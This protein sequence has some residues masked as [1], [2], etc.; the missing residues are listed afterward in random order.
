MLALHCMSVTI[1]VALCCYFSCL[2]LTISNNVA[3]K[4][5]LT[6]LLYLF[7][8]TVTIPYSFYSLFFFSYCCKHI[9]I[10]M[11]ICLLQL[12]QLICCCNYIWVSAVIIVL[13]C[14]CCCCCCCS[15]CVSVVAILQLPSGKCIN[16]TCGKNWVAKLLLHENV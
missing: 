4:K 11:Y 7:V 13:Y 6:I 15:C 3:I 9:H 8:A 5:L 2:V 12:L 14:Y 10:D 16:V 1:V